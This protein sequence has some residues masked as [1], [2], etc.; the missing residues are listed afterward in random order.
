MLLQGFGPDIKELLGP[1]LFSPQRKVRVP[2]R[3]RPCANTATD[4]AS[5]PHPPP[6]SPHLSVRF[7]RVATL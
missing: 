3:V 7:H 5:R 4:L 1:I 6:L 2:A